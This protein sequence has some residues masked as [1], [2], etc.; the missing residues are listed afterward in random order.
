MRLL[1]MAHSWSA[2]TTQGY[3]SKI[4]KVARFE[5]S[6][7][8]LDILKPSHIESPPAGT[9]IPTMWVELDESVRVLKAKGRFEERTPVY[10][11]V[12][13]I[14]SAVSQYQTWDMMVSSGGNSYFLERRHVE[15]TCRSTDNAAYALYNRGLAARIGSNPKPC[16]PLLGRNVIWLDRWMDKRYR[17]A[18]TWTERRNW[19]MAGTANA[20]L[21]LGWLRGGEAFARRWQDLSIIEPRAG[22][23]YDLPPNTGAILLNMGPETKSNRIHEVDVAIAYRTMSGLELGKW[24]HRLYSSY[25]N[26]PDPRSYIFSTPDGGRWRSFYYRK[27]YL[28][29]GLSLQRLEGDPYLRDF[30]GVN[31]RFRN[32][33]YNL[34]CYRRGARSHVERSQPGPHRKASREQIYEHG[35]WQKKRGNEPIDLQYRA[36]TLW[37]RLRITLWSH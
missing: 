35:R 36:W 29:P 24:V 14:R 37:E 10:G 1:D 17:E 15:G 22:P 34:H 16:T 30:D 11:T 25:P 19:A 33:F 26:G 6:H 4:R 8:G 7:P 3:Q 13:Q 23:F 31:K 9:D 2:G 28:Y 27:T 5:L 20:L 18:P 12:R 21:W 32:Y